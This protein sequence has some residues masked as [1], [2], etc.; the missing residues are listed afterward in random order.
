MTIRKHALLFGLA[1][2]AGLTAA[3]P[4]ASAWEMKVCVDFNRMP[5]SNEAGTGY[6]IE[7]AQVIAD[8]LGADL[9][10]EWWPSREV[11]INNALRPGDCDV[12]MGA[13]EEGTTL[14]TLA[15]YRS[16]FVFVYRAGEGYDVFTFDDP[17]LR[18]LRLGVQPTFGPTHQALM[19][20]DLGEAIEEYQYVGGAEH[21]LAPAIEAVANDEIDVAIVWGPAAGYYAARQDV[22]LV[23]QPVPPFDPPFTP[24]YINIS[25]GVRLGD[26]SLRDAIDIALA[27]RWDEIYAI[28]DAYNIPTMSLPRPTLTIEVP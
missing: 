16:P 12:V 28:L 1:A 5:L 13:T 2:L 17:I 11:L 10:F 3:A 14:N 26:E 23:V 21:P 27:N 6:E 25:I 4:P 22:E 9:V 24:M 15:Y 8:E 19:R 20:R 7:I 18:E